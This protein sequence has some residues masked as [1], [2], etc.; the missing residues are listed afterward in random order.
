MRYKRTDIVLERGVQGDVVLWMRTR[1]RNWG[2]WEE[3][4]SQRGTGSEPE[5]EQK[6]IFT[7]SVLQPCVSSRTRHHASQCGS[8]TAPLVHRLRLHLTFTVAVD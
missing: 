2:H 8:L 1:E 7:P 3:L 5:V 6:P 4:R